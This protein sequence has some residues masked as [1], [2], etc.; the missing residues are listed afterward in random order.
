M[1]RSFKRDW[2]P[3]RPDGETGRMIP[4]PV[5]R[6]GRAGIVDD[7]RRRMGRGKETGGILPR[8]AVRALKRYRARMERRAARQWVREGTPDVTH[9]PAHPPRPR[10]VPIPPDTAWIGY[11]PIRLEADGVYR[12]LAGFRRYNGY[13]QIAAAVV[14]QS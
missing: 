5:A 3:W 6:A 12:L 2:R 9:G 13:Q 14:R 11:L 8:L 7:P 10:P 4:V 1:S